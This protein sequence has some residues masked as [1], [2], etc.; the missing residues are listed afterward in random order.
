M[1]IRYEFTN[2]EISEIEVD[3]TLGGL[4]VELDRQEYNNDHKETHRHVSLDG[5][6]YEGALFASPD[7]PAAEVLRQEDAPRLLRAMEALSPSQ[8]ELVRRVYF[9]RERI[10]DIARTEGLTKQ[11]IHKRLGRTLKN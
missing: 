5:L 7:D 9:K 4:L 1:N 3:E 6:D 2:G 8:R 10:V 11:S